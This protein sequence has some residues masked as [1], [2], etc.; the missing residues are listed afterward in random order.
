MNET[1][2][3]GFTVMVIGMGVVFAF[4]TL[5]IFVMN[6]SAKVIEYIN[7]IWPEPVPEVK[8]PKKKKETKDDAQIALAITL[9]FDKEAKGKC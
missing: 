4:L 1:L 3:L 2:M 8:A 5:M 6:I 7:K 9:A